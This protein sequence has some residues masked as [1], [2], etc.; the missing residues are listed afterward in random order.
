MTSGAKQKLTALE[1]VVLGLI[2]MKPQSGYSI[3]NYLEAGLS[4]YSASPGS[5]YPILKRL[6]AASVIDGLLESEH[7]TRQRRIYTLTMH[8][9]LLL[10]AWLRDV[11]KAS[12]IFEERE[13]GMWRFQFME[14]R[15]AHDEVIRWLD[16]YLDAIRIF[17]YGKRQFYDRTRDQMNVVGQHSTHQEL[18]MESVLMELN[19]L[20]TWLEMARARLMMRARAT[21]E[22]PKV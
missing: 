8:G 9:G 19:T 12:P 1:Y 22:M 2:G 5:V 21:G 10:D 7:E 15:L 3:I 17:D 16:E 13:L 18:I 14:A 11:P 6:E 4:G 20:R